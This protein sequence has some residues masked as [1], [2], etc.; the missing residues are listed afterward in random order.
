MDT[1]FD[2]WLRC[3][4]PILA[5]AG[6]AWVLC[7]RR[8][9]V[10]LIDV[11]W[12]G[13]FVVAGATSLWR[14]QAWSM[15][16]LALAAVILAWALRLSAHL[17]VRNWNAAE[18]RR[19]AAMRARHEP[20]FAWK[21]LYLVFG[22]QAVLA[23]IIAAP[24][25]AG[26]GASAAHAPTWAQAV[27]WSLGFVLAVA[28][29]VIE[30]LADAQLAAFKAQDWDGGAVL[31]TGLW[32]YSRHPNYFG[33]CCLWWGVFAMAM[34]IRPD[35]W[36]IVVSPLLMTYLLLRVSG[37]PMLERDIDLR[38]PAYRAYIA[39]TPAFFPRIPRESSGA[40]AR[41]PAP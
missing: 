38:R 19:Y 20:G 34:A 27:L 10:G 37:V 17:A 40:Q 39:R 22:L 23:W 25:A 6:V 33:E 41:E 18:D 31:D 36:W 7:T 35:S 21:S 5:L 2:T 16:S 12:P 8:R 29:I 28:G 14:S 24:L 15:Q 1:A 13:F 30:S 4:P 9:N 3:L 11:F 32:R 26:L